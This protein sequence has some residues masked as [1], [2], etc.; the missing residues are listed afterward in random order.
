MYL[1]QLHIDGFGTFTDYGVTDLQPGVNILYGANEAGKSTLLKFIR[2]TLF[3]YPRLVEQRLAPL[4]GGGHGGRVNA[5][6]SDGTTAIFERSAGYPGDIQLHADDT[7]G[8]RAD[9]WFRL[10]GHASAD[11]FENVYAIT[12]DELVGLESLNRSGVED[13][14]FSVGLGLKNISINDIE[15]QLTTQMEAIYKPRGSKQQAIVRLREIEENRREIKA[16]QLHL[17][18]YRQLTREIEQHQQMLKKMEAELTALQSRHDTLGN[19]QKSYESFVLLRDLDRELAALPEW[20]EYPENGLSRMEQLEAE[21]TRLRRQATDLKD[22]LAAIE[23]DDIDAYNEALAAR[24]EPVERLSLNLEKYKTWA[25][26]YREDRLALEELNQSIERRLAAINAEWTED[27]ILTF[28]DAVIHEDRLKAF[29]HRLETLQQ[30]QDR[31]Q[32]EISLLKARR[33]PIHAQNACVVFGSALVIGASTLILFKIFAWGT[34]LMIIGLILLA[35]R[36]VV[37]MDDPLREASQASAWLE[38][39]KAMALKEFQQYIE[40]EL[41][42]PPEMSPEAA[43][44]ALKLIGQIS[45]DIDARDRYQ[46]RVAEKKAFIRAF[47]NDLDDLAPFLS[48][49]IAETDKTLLAARIVREH[50]NALALKNKAEQKRNEEERLRETLGKTEQARLRVETEINRLLTTIQATNRED[51]KKKYRQNCRADDLKQQRRQTLRTIEQIVGVHDRQNA[52][53]CLTAMEK[54]VLETSLRQS[55]NRLQ[56]LRSERDELNRKISADMT[57]RD[58][59]RTS[60][61]LGEAMTRLAIARENLNRC[62][63]EWLAAKIAGHVLEQVKSQY[64]QKKQPAVIRHSSNFFRRITGDRYRRIQVS[65]EDGQVLVFDATGASRRIDQLSRGTREQLLISIRLG[66]IEEYE[67][68]TE[69]LPLILDEILV[70]F[71]LERAERTAAILHEFSAGRQTL[72]FTCH[73]ET[74]SLF[75]KLPINF[76]TI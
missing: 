1:T 36:K 60:S 52:I 57:R 5:R 10:L 11:L 14:I 43:R 62:Q 74:K 13:K 64:E 54:P 42:L 47:E 51:F 73:P 29:Q 44:E 27:N 6:L 40:T 46:R 25:E 8:D 15:Q 24:E 45:R 48:D 31:L 75:G 26:E 38:A 72:L 68:R 63:R 19:Y 33:S 56:T 3:G 21:E 69:A 67:K 37:V 39:E 16:I 4:H 30:N 2:F 41:G 20:R 70:N 9:D 66:F 53:A 32:T 12:L 7:I 18:Q 22:A 49:N 61:H 35:G 17:P 65:L 76:I 28:T 71:D 58:Q 34:V 23:A 59:L 50:K 55:E